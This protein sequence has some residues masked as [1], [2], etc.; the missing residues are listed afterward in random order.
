MTG[1]DPKSK[2]ASTQLTNKHR[3]DWNAYVMWL[4]KI[5]MKGNPKL[6]EG[7]TGNKLLASYISQNPNTSLTLDIVPVIQQDFGGYRDWSLSEVKAGRRALATGVTPENFLRDLSKVDG[8]AG[9]RTTSFMF[10]KAYM[11]VV[12]NGKKQKIDKGYSTPQTALR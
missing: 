11:E 2:P 12:H 9:Q 3:E 6:D 5:G 7:D 4:D 1:E 8:I 10:P